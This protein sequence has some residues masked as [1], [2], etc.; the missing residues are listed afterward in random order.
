MAT[1]LQSALMVTAPSGA[2]DSH[3]LVIFSIMFLA[4]ILG[5]IANFFLA[6]R[7][8]DS[9]SRDWMRYPV[10]G[11]VAALTVPL[12]LN[13]IS[14][15]LLEG[16]RTKPTDF[17]VFAGFCLM[18]VVA[19]RRLF[20]N[21]AIKLLAQIDQVKRDM[22]HLKQRR[23]MLPQAPKEE[24]TEATPES[25]PEPRES[26]SYS[27]IEILR[28]LSEESYVYGNLASLCEKTRLGREL[29][30]QR[31]MVM[32]SMGVIETRINEK[33]VLHWFVSPRGKQVLGEIMAAEE[34]K[35][36]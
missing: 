25:K 31:L 5:G 7:S 2:L 30:N 22:Q 15:T 16:A 10:L 1:E 8:S 11:V 4:G 9:A 19:S 20:E 24:K 35:T 36:A 28:A 3:M 12:F 23:E 17:Y 13:M 34:K 18:Y 27:D 32:K 33:N 6:E 14:S 26:L 21:V 29:V